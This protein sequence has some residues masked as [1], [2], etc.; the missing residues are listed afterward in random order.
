MLNGE[1]NII[2]ESIIH[3]RS[4]DDERLFSLIEALPPPKKIQLE[5]LRSEGYSF[6]AGLEKIGVLT[7]Q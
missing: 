3:L 2:K 6:L 1:N 5:R 4:E 7:A